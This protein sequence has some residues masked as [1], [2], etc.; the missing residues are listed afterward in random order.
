MFIFLSKFIPPLVYPLG[1]ACILIGVGLLAERKLYLRRT[2]FVAALM[3]LWLG[4]NRW[5]AMSLGRS[6]EWRYLPPNPM[7]SAEVIV[8][9]GGGTEPGLYPRP[10]VGLNAAADRE[11]YAAWLYHQGK[12][13]YILVS[14]REISWLFASDQGAG[15]MASVLAMLGVPPEAIW[16]ENESLNTYENALFCRKILE[17]K[18]FHRIILVTSAAH[19]PRSVALFQKQGF[20]VIPAPTDFTITQADWQRLVEPNLPAQLIRLIPS[21][22][23]LYATSIFLKEYLGMFIYRLRG[24]L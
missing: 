7:P 22:E 21:A 4:G 5:V 15:D 10:M 19:M 2:L 3:L 6:L 18:G 8:L 24:W 11:L 16:I 23:N 13:P 17:E 1:L 9:L 14:G 20:E 12:A